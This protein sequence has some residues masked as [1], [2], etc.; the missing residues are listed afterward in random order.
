M[1]VSTRAWWIALYTHA[2][3]V[4][5]HETL[6][7]RPAVAG[8]RVRPEA[9]SADSVHA[10]MCRSRDT[11][12]WY[13]IF[14]RSYK[15]FDIQP[16]RTTS[17]RSDE[18]ENKTYETRIYQPMPLILPTVGAAF[19]RLIILQ[20]VYLWIFFVNFFFPLF[21]SQYFSPARFFLE[22]F[23]RL[24]IYV[25]PIRIAAFCLMRIINNTIIQCPLYAINTPH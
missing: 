10:S 20:S 13:G 16:R 23:C 18:N 11:T 14:F 8:A 4:Q 15:R 25:G 6:W 3:S 24:I 1:G 12:R 9:H 5:V 17:A 21:R 2:Y 22:T 19:S 7:P